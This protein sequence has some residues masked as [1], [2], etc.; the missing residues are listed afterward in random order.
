M[1]PGPFEDEKV[2]SHQQFV[3]GIRDGLRSAGVKEGQYCGHNFHTGAVT[4]AV[5]KGI[6]VII[7]AGAHEPLKA[8]K[9]PVTTVPSKYKY[10]LAATVTDVIARFECYYLYTTY[11]RNRRDCARN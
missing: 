11:G 10:V 7:E 2:L 9:E 5:E 4:T 1:A 8:A 3:D 6:D